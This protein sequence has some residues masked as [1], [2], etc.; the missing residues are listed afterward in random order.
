MRLGLLILAVLLVGC[1]ADSRQ[2]PSAPSRDSDLPAARD[3]YL[4][5]CSMCPRADAC[6][7]KG[8]DFEPG[9]WSKASGRYLRAMRDHFDCMRGDVLIDKTLYAEPPLVPDLPPPPV[10][11]APPLLPHT[12]NRASCELYACMSSAA[13]MAA[14]LDLALATPTRHRMGAALACPVEE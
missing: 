1:S 2:S 14:E 4:A 9:T 3:A 7:L 5:Y 12:G 13:T 8:S 10:P 11:P 6:C